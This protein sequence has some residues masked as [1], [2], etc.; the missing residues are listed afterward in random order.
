MSSTLVAS[1]LQRILG[2]ALD[3]NWCP[4]DVD[5]MMSP[6][7]SIPP[8]LKWPWRR[9]WVKM[10][11]CL[12]YEVTMNL[13]SMKLPSVGDSIRNHLWLVVAKSSESIP[14][15]GPDW[16]AHMYHYELPWV[17]HVPLCVE[18]NKV[19]FHHTIRDI[20]F[21]WSHCNRT[22]ELSFWLQSLL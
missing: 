2:T 14:I 16:R 12:M 21:V 6:M 1:P 5:G 7:T 20:I 13:T 18:D 11:W 22:E 8:H 4:L 3:I 17:P 10:V 9:R 15:L 19:E